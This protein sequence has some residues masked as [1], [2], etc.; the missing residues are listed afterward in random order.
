MVMTPPIH[1]EVPTGR[2]RGRP[3]RWSSKVVMQIEVTIQQTSMSAP[4]D[5]PAEWSTIKVLWRDADWRDLVYFAT[6]YV[7]PNA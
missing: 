6:T 7:S 5:R 1:R 4:N 3:S 2:V